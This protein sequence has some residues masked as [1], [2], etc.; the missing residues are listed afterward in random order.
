[1][2]RLILFGAALMLACLPA[3]AEEPVKLKV[4]MV[5]AVDMLALP[6]ALE[7]GFFEKR[8]LDATIARPYARRCAQRIAGR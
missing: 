2:K 3:Q 4:G 1:M 5:S 8:G 7:R 6:V